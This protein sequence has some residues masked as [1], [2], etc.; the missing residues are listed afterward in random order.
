[1]PNPRAVFLRTPGLVREGARSLPDTACP[2]TA[3]GPLV[4]FANFR[5][6]RFVPVTAISTCRSLIEQQRNGR[7]YVNRPCRFLRGLIRAYL[8]RSNT[9]RR[10]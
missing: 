5:G 2:R 8:E 4:I 6:H 1:M 9:V 3:A 10:N 7:H